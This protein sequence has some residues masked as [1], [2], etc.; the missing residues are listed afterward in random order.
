MTE[1]PRLVTSPGPIRDKD[2]NVIDWKPFSY[3]L[4]WVGDGERGRADCVDL[5]KVRDFVKEKEPNI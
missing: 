2:G 3:M 4:E 5:P 1:P